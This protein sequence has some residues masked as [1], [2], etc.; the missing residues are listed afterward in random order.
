MMEMFDRP[1]LL[2][3]HLEELRGRLIKVVGVVVIGLLLG[4]AF[5]SNSLT[6][7]QMWISEFNPSKTSD[8]ESQFVEIILQDGT[9]L[10]KTK[11][12]R[13]RRC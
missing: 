2:G 9:D 7:Q 11:L 3:D 4:F 10:S 5:H 13:P 8:G 12:I 6:A 1:M